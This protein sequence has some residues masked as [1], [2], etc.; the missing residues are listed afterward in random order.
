MKNK[1]LVS[2]IVTTKNEEKNIANCLES[3][4]DQS[5]KHIEIIVV[6]NNSS[7]M[8]KTIARKYSSHI[9]NKGPE[10][11]AQRNF[12]VEQA[13]GSYVLFIDSDMVLS[14]DV[15]KESIEEITKRKEL[16]A[17]IIP[18]E[19]FGEGFWANCKK[20]ERSFYLGV[21]WIE[22][23]RFFSRKAFCT[24]GGFNELMIS[25]EDWELTQRIRERY[26]VGR[27]NSFIYHNEGKLQLR[28]TIKKKYYYAKNIVPYL[29]ERHGKS[30]IANQ[31]NPIKRYA[32]YFSDTKKLFQNPLISI[33]MFIMKTSEFSAGLVGYIFNRKSYEEY[34]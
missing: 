31:T 18:E 32:L 25:G 16:A 15:V 26:S 13:N 20:L 19:S 4:K 28:D 23:A 7:D 27:I 14:K 24:L 8:T 11:S 17:I 33:G 21:E 2:V 34:N 1:P 6:D 30:D 12:G 5:Y 9:F 29:S 3:I 10:R 22:A